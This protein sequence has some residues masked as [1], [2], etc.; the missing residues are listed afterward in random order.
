VHLSIFVREMCLLRTS[1]VRALRLVL[2]G[3]VVVD[4]SDD[5]LV[6]HDRCPCGRG[7]AR[8]SSAKAC[9]YARQGQSL[10]TPIMP[11][12]EPF[13]LMILSDFDY[14]IYEELAC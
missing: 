9:C 14:R 7:E 1:E 3:L 6:N 2:V 4:A 5:P 13:G 10:S 8:G 12:V 11:R